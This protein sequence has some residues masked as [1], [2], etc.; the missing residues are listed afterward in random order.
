M[1][2]IAILFTDNFDPYKYTNR[3]MAKLHLMTYETLLEDEENQVMG[4]THVADVKGVTAAHVTLWNPA[5]FT[6]AFRWGEVSIIGC[7]RGSDGSEWVELGNELTLTE[8][9][10]NGRR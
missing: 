1:L 9:P 2:C 10:H 7:G 5:E 6:T 4:F 8:C 3:E